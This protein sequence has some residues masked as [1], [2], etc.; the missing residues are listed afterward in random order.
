MAF[1]GKITAA[2][3]ALFQASSLPGGDPVIPAKLGVGDANGVPYTP[4]GN[5]TAL[6]NERYRANL[7]GWGLDPED[8]TILIASL[9]IPA[10]EGGYTIHEV[11]L[12]DADDVLLVICRHPALYK[13]AVGEGAA[14]DVEIKLALVIQGDAS[15]AIQLD[16][17]QV[18]ATRSWVETRVSEQV[19][20]INWDQAS[21]IP[22]GTTRVFL[23]ATDQILFAPTKDAEDGHRLWAND[24]TAALLANAALLNIHL[25]DT[26]PEGAGFE[27]KLW[28]DPHDSNTGPG[29]FKAWNGAAWVAVTAGQVFSH[30]LLN[31][32]DHA[33][34]QLTNNGSGGLSWTD[35]TGENLGEAAEVFKS[36]SAGKLGLRSIRGIDGLAA[37]V[38]EENDEILVGPS[39][40]A[41]S[42]LVLVKRE[43]ITLGA[44]VGVDPNTAAVLWAPQYTPVAAGHRLGVRFAARLRLSVGDPDTAGVA[45]TMVSIQAEENSGGGYA[46]LG[47]PADHIGLQTAISAVD[48]SIQ[49][50]GCG[51]PLEYELAS[52]PA[53]LF[54]VRL[55]SGMTAGFEAPASLYILAGST[56]CFEEYAE[57]TLLAGP[58]P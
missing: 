16:P 24:M 56:V 27:K 17:S 37:A 41:V 32:L 9:V 20:D 52:T 36:K 29:A 34:G 54:T 30:L 21:V 14:A 7:T 38:D 40:G 46:A 57:A 53:G 2:G 10:G 42:A 51:L 13:P 8:D 31:K 3:R 1:A 55:K 33:A 28:Y 49:E 22:R 45:S 12:Y 47:A 19:T 35:I 11:G 44:D 4:T 39:G 50:F 23:P 18:L 58:A 26:A 5:E 6:V 15:I 25:S 43:L 48:S